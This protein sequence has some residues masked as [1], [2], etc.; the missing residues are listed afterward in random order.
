MS[1]M[2]WRCT[3]AARMS[4]C[5]KRSPESGM[6]GAGAGG[7]GGEVAAAAAVPGVIEAAAVREGVGTSP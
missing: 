7:C 4:D 2:V 5:V 6:S 1:P 3:A